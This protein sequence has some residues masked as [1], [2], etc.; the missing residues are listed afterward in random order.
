MKCRVVSLDVRNFLRVRAVHV[1]PGDAGIVPITGPNGAGKSSVLRAIAVAVGGARQCPEKPIRRGADSAEIR[2]DLGEFSMIWKATKSGERLEVRD[3]DGNK[4]PA[5]QSVLDKLYTDLTADPLAL[6]RLAP[7]KQV[8]VLKQVAGLEGAFK[9]LDARRETAV[10]ERTI[11]NREVASLEGRLLALPPEEGPDEEVSVSTIMERSTAAQIENTRNTKQRL[12][13]V[14]NEGKIADTRADIEELRQKLVSAES[15][16]K[17]LEA[18]D[19]QYRPLVEKLVDVDLEAIKREALD[20]EGRN[21]IARR[22]MARAKVVAELKE[23]KAKALKLDRAV[24]DCNAEREQAIAVA[25]MPVQGLAF[26]DDGV[27]LNGQPFAQAST[28]EQIRAGVAMGMASNP[29]LRV[30]LV[31]DGSLLDSNSLKLLEQL[32]EEYDA[33]IWLERVADAAGAEGFAIEDGTLAE[34]VQS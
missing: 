5:Q 9:V 25:K 34:E 33:Q 20:I 30:M 2:L 31:K 10:S 27:T 23:A 4:V 32:A 21:A 16:L 22:R 8:E 26:T 1:E 3:K 24:E 18:L 28:A 17:E 6:P 14:E 13:L 7:A 11:A 29:A 12:W 19:V 15:K